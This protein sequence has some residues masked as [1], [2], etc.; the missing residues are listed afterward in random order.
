M[1]FAKTT[2]V[3]CYIVRKNCIS[4]WLYDS[5]YWTLASS[6]ERILINQKTKWTSNRKTALNFINFLML[7]DGHWRLQLGSFLIG[8]RDSIEIYKIGIKFVHFLELDV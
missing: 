3:I 1:V 7:V 6:F 2:P 5:R 4:E 8:C